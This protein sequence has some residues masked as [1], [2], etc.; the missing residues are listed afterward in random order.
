VKL[1][2][3]KTEAT[4]LRHVTFV[5]QSKATLVSNRDSADCIDYQSRKRGDL[6][7]SRY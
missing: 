1:T 5:E 3:M 4:A 6:G 7:K 2:E